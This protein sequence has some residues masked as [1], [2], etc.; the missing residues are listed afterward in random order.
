[1]HT[2]NLRRSGFVGTFLLAGCLTFVNANVGWYVNGAGK[3]FK[4]INSGTSWELQLNRSG[5]FFRCVA[6]LDEQN[7]FAGNIGPSYFPGVTDSCPL[8]ETEDRLSN[9]L[10]VELGR[11][12]RA[13]FA[14]QRAKSQEFELHPK[15]FLAE[16][17]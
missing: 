1:M 12:N 4:T 7:G 14:H 13:M 11:T 10:T 5:T 17:G 2:D 6:F 8:Y 9:L 3:I 16:T 15:R